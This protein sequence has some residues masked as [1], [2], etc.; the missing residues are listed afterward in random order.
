M[1][2]S[3]YLPNTDADRRAMLD[4]IGVPSAEALFQDI[5]QR[6]CHAAFDL[7]APLSELELKIELRKISE[8][9][10]NS[11]DF[12]CFLGAGYYN[13]FVPS[14]VSHL[15]GR[16]EFYTSY[17]P[18]QAEISQGT[19]QAL[20]EFQSMVSAL[21]G[22]DVANAGMYDGST[23]AAEAALMACRITK[24][25]KIAVQGTV[26]PN[27]RDVIKTYAWWHDISFE[28]CSLD[29]VPS[30]T[31][32]IVIQQPD[33]FGCFDDITSLIEN[34]HKVGALIVVIAN[35]ISLGM[36]KAPGDYG[37]D[38]VAAEGQPL[39]N[40][41]NFG[42][43]GVGLFA[44]RKDFVRQMPGR[45]VGKTIDA[46]GHPGYVLTLATREQHI[47]RER[48]T[49]NICT[50]EALVAIAATVYLAAMGKTGLRQVA[51]L[52]YQKA[53]YAASEISKLKGY[54]LAFNK[55]FF[56]E[57]VVKCPD[58]PAEINLT[59]LKEHIIGGLDVSGSVPDGML[60][61]A[62]EMNTKEDIDRL[63]KCLGKFSGGVR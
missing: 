50:S 49:S 15:T 6:Y 42:G 5:P 63:V 16:S 9:N 46:D 13:H 44:C 18:Y 52:S 26:N 4:K 56:N 37:A 29:A 61:C 8:V 25:E 22:M 28:I 24:R 7:P 17:T 2:Q 23:A 10:A 51:E 43:P 20:Y 33:F 21:T 48:A 53:H 41:E 58:N 40:A 62:T 36:Y 27:Y 54:S 59:L 34:A 11:N 57:F 39:G 45:L 30:D 60:L 3:P 35:P 47:R 1:S 14:I 55:P 19:L 12:A 32:C 38:I 31:A